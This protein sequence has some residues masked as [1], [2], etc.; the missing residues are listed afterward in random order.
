M[1]GHTTKACFKLNGYPDRYKDLKEKKK[2]N[3]TFAHMAHVN[4]GD[5]N[6]LYNDQ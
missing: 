2:S 1:T 4:Q 3:F 5:N 6:P